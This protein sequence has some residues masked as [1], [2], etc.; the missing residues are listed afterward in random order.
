MGLS[1]IQKREASPWRT[2]D[3]G[4][5]GASDH[6]R[7]SIWAFA[8]S[9]LAKRADM[10]AV[11]EDGF[12]KALAHEWTGEWPMPPAGEREG[13][14][15][16]FAAGEALGAGAAE[17]L[18]R[19]M[20]RARA[21]DIADGQW[22]EQAWSRMTPFGQGVFLRKSIQARDIR[23]VRAALAAGADPCAPVSAL[24]STALMVAANSDFELAFDLLLPLS[25]T[26]AVNK[27]GYTALNMAC[28][29]TVEGDAAEARI[30][31]IRALLPAQGQLAPGFSPLISLAVSG[32]WTPEALALVEPVSD[33]FARLENGKTALNYFVEEG[34]WPAANRLA[35][36]MQ[37]IDPHRAAQAARAAAEEPL[38]WLERWRARLGDKVEPRAIVPGSVARGLDFLCSL[39]L[40]TKSQEKRLADLSPC[41][42][43][44]LAPMVLAR[45]ERRDINA[46]VSEAKKPEPIVATPD[47][48][49]GPVAAQSA[50]A[51]RR[52]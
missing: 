31:W 27:K 23:L 37:G 2:A 51:R 48:T 47:E 41:T 29:R 18:T 33:P 10:A 9:D 35:S 21:A 49:P 15:S 13:V 19:L 24:Q 40:L 30:D 8:W 5:E 52:L 32:S 16:R 36:R 6:A 12:S 3:S 17:E 7:P 46:A 20:E 38:A 11:L 34:C 44:V 14:L 26:Q 25:D 43:P 42:E 4:P 50:R 39:N 28:E 45:K 22:L 1:M